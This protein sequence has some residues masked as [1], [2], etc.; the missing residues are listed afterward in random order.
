M[1]FERRACG[2]G[3]VGAGKIDFESQ[4]ELFLLDA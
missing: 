2:G 3:G 4:K 1:H